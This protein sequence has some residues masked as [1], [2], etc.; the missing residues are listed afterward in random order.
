MEDI[1]AH[2]VVTRLLV[3]AGALLAEAEGEPLVGGANAGGL[4]GE[5]VSVAAVGGDDEGVPE[6]DP[7]QPARLGARVA[8]R[9]APWMAD[10]AVGAAASAVGRV[11]KAGQNHVED[12]PCVAAPLQNRRCHAHAGETYCFSSL[13]DLIDSIVLVGEQ[14]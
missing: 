7:G 9:G 5:E 8:H 3:V 10:V 4:V 1:V 13:F 11:R 2:D 14:P 6:R 12:L